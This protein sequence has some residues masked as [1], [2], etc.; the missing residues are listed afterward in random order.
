MIKTILYLFSVFLF[1]LAIATFFVETFLSWI[2]KTSG[3]VTGSG[4]SRDL[5]RAREV[6]QSNLVKKSTGNDAEQ[7]KSR[8]AEDLAVQQA[9]MDSQR[10]TSRGNRQPESR[11]LQDRLLKEQQDL[12][13]FHSLEMD[14]R[15]DLRR[16]E[17]ERIRKEEEARR[18][19][20][21]RRR[22]EEEQRLRREDE[23]RRDERLRRLTALG[24][25]PA[26]GVWLLLRLPSGSRLRRRFLATDALQKVFDFVSGNELDLVSYKLVTHFPK[27]SFTESADAARTLVETGLENNT[28]MYVEQDV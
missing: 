3:R 9:I 27:K 16:S 5:A 11:I 26:E 12:E 14:R 28:T 2:R 25:P 6:Q 13:Y 7:E 20:E 10:T 24:E 19:E 23:R 15:R 21:E 4:L 1:F 18:A 22:N 17:E 8:I